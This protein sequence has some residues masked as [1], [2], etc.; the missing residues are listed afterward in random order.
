MQAYRAT[1]PADVVYGTVV[2]EDP[3]EIQIDTKMVLDESFLILTK[4]VSKSEIEVDIDFSGDGSIE[5]EE[6]EQTLLKKL[7]ITGAKITIHNEIQT[8]DTVIMQKKQGGQEYII[9]DKL[10]REGG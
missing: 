10:E 2:S 1:N 9:L 6:L 8:G 5:I 3:L 7:S 4:N